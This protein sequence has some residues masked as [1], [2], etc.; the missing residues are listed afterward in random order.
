MVWPIPLGLRPKPSSRTCV[1]FS[2]GGC[3]ERCP[4]VNS[5]YLGNVNV[6]TGI[7]RDR[8][9][10]DHERVLLGGPLVAPACQELTSDVEYADPGDQI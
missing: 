7:D 3:Q 4:E 8:M 1:S 10:G 6:A 5:H 9:E 2:S